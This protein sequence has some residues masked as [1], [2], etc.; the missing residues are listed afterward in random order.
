M[1]P[2]DSRFDPGCLKLMNY[3]GVRYF[4][5]ISPNWSNI[6]PKTG[7]L[8]DDHSPDAWKS[9]LW[10]LSRQRKSVRDK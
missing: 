2:G 5:A 7:L 1:F 8:K 4:L 6:S 10:K 3:S 9:G